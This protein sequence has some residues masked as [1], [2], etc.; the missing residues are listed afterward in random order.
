[1]YNV[2]GMK[3]VI[4][5]DIDGT[6]LDGSRGMK[7]ASDKTRYAFEELKKDNYVFIASGR[8]KGLLNDKV[9][10]LK[11]NG[12]ILCNGAYAEFEDKPIYSFCFEESVLDKVKEVVKKYDGFYIF[13]T[14]DA[15]Y[16]ESLESESFNSFIRSWNITKNGFSDD[17]PTDPIHIAMIGFRDYS[18]FDN[19]KEELKDYADAI[20]HNGFSSFDI[21]IKGINKGTGVIKIREYLGIP[22]ENT[23]CFG[24]GINDLEMLLEVGHPIAMGNCDRKLDGYG[25][26]KTD[27]VLD[28]GFYNYLVSHKL[29]KAL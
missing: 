5:C 7:E 8:C 28:E 11:P 18:A 21:N 25:F 17:R 10:S 6:I 23:Y 15:M 27:D 19:V 24:D 26:E 13:E 9:T 3:N 12:Y 22:K 4:F 14:L 20:P 16:V 1:M 29:I 2:Q